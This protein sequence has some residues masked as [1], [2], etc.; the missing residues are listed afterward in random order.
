[1]PNSALFIYEYEHQEPAPQLG[2]NPLIFI[3]QTSPSCTKIIKIYPRP[4]NIFLTLNFFLTQN[5]FWTKN[6][7][8]D[9]K[10]FWDFLG[11]RI[12]S[13]TRFFFG[14]TFF[15][16]PKSFQTQKFCL[17]ENKLQWKWS[18]ERGNRGSELEVL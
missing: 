3:H 18:L 1:M 6:F 10:F 15:W 14:Q 9:P 7:F 16:E 4:Q 11:P 5:I 12:F 13:D 8:S 17:T 2:L